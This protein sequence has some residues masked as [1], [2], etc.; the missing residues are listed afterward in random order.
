[1][2]R[3]Y[4]IFEKARSYVSGLA[5]RARFVMSAAA[6]KIQIVAKTD[7]H[8]ILKFYRSA[9]DRNSGKVIVVKRNPRAYWID[10]YKDAAVPK[11]FSKGYDSHGPE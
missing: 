8:M 6:G 4:D 11:R 1:M 3:G 5:K 9:D 7:K 10:D 2:E